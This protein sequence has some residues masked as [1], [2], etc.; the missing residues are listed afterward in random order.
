[1]GNFYVNHSV[2]ATN[3]VAV[4]NLLRGRQAIVT[5]AISGWVVVADEIA[6]TQ[7]TP[8]IEQLSQMLSGNL[9]TYVFA[10]LNHDDDVL[11]YDLYL[12]A[13]PIDSYNSSPRYFDGTG[14]S[15]RPEGGKADLL[16][17]AFDSPA[18]AGVESILREELVL[19]EAEKYFFAW[20]R[21]RDLMQA[22]GQPDASVGFG[23]KYAS[24]GELPASRKDTEL[25]FVKP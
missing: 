1:M 25:I 21:H 4:A 7:F 3:P 23:Y 15:G 5:A 20:Q 9:K 6:D 2:K 17:R 19:N 16:C 8:V 10:I 13:A 14:E 18:I 22:L 12:N 11:C 24:Q